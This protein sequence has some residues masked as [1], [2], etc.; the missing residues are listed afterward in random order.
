M[1]GVGHQ[2][3]NYFKHTRRT[4]RMHH[5][6]H[7]PEIN[8]DWQP[9]LLLGQPPGSTKTRGGPVYSYAASTLQRQ[10]GYRGAYNIPTFSNIRSFLELPC[11][12]SDAWSE[13]RVTLALLLST[14]GRHLFASSCSRSWF[15]T[16]MKNMIVWMFGRHKVPSL[17]LCCVP[18]DV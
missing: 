6:C 13:R 15:E 4:G 8:W 10:L 7:N 3:Q 12:M 2:H 17:Q 9:A 16:L 11:M 1:S 5:D 18:F 14:Q